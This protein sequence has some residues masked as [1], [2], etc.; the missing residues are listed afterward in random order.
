MLASWEEARKVW[1]DSQRDAFEKHCIEPLTKEVKNAVDSMDQML[2]LL[3]KV[4]QD[5]E[6]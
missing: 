4:R 6:E 2:T 1:R 3:Q 5:C